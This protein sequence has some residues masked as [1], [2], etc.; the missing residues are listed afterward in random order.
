MRFRTPPTIAVL[1]VFS[2]LSTPAALGQ[3]LEQAETTAA[4]AARTAETA[5]GLVDEA[6][7]NRAQIEV[8]LAASISRANDLASTL[9][10]LG[11]S[12]DRLAEQMGFADIELA[13]IKAQI[14]VQAVDAYM[15]VLASPSLSLVG[16]GSVEEAL[17]VSTVVE[18]VVTDN[19]E[20]VDELFI[21]R[22]SLEELQRV[23]LSQQEEYARLQAEVDAEVEHLVEL[24]GEAD[25]EVAEA[26]QRAREAD[27]EYRAALGAVDL[28]RV[29]E[30]ERVRQ[31]N[32]ETTDTT[33]PPPTTGTTPTTT[34]TTPPTTG[35]GGSVPSSF[36]SHIEQWR[37]LVSEHFPASRV[38]EALA[39]IRCESNG[40][41][42]AYN[43]YSGASGLFQFLPFTWATTA[44][45]AGYGGAS[46]FDPVANVATAAWLANRYQELGQSYWQ[47]WSCRRVLG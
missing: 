43:P 4:D 39:I 15:S 8:E 18:E 30:A 27:L 46:V 25:A 11:A 36:P 35:G 42:D 29:R 28:A 31:D 37:G 41:P 13:G 33:S 34:A 1:L 23:Y 7:A 6:V 10:V 21:K 19:R 45:K 14:E 40:D 2:L 12:L 38:N 16:T 26:V 20:S 5:S 3:D 22:R 17:V 9:S 47:A 24:Y 44:P 32:R